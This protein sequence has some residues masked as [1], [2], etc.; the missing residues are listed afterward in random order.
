[1]KTYKVTV[2]QNGEESTKL[3]QAENEEQAKREVEQQWRLG[4]GYIADYSIRAEEV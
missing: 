2:L 3:I 1:M 4:K